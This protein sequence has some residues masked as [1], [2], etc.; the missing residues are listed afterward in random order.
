MRLSRTMLALGVLFA[1]VMALLLWRYDPWLFASALN[2]PIVT[3]LVIA[4]AVV[5]LVVTFAYSVQD[6]KRAVI[7]KEGRFDRLEPGGRM[8]LWPGTEVGTEISLAEQRVLGWPIL[9]YDQKGAETSIILGLTWRIVPTSTKPSFR[10]QRMLLATNDERR[11]IVIQAL[12]STIREIARCTTVE[13]LKGV[14]TNPRCVEAIRQVVAEQLKDD[15]LTLDRLHVVRFIPA[16]K[17]DEP[18]AIRETHTVTETR[19]WADPPRAIEPPRVVESAPATPAAPPARRPDP[20]DQWGAPDSRL[21]YPLDY[22]ARP[23]SDQPTAG[24]D[25]KPEGKAASGSEPSA[26]AATPPNPG[27]AEPPAPGRTGWWHIERTEEHTRGIRIK[28]KDKDKEK[29]KDK[30]KGKDADK[31]LCCP[32]CDR[33]TDA[34]PRG[35]TVR[36]CASCGGPV[37]PCA[38]CGGQKEPCPRCGH[39]PR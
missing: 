20:T 37:A 2:H 6:P 36:F 14:L 23:A 1:G 29:E 16:E 35:L 19:S 25:A 38:T 8:L 30:E 4:G 21:I 22:P 7:F 24:A 15:A 12:E 17:K 31:P 28:D 3:A 27:A 10:E 34:Q 13:N 32:E 33:P 5:W 39:T 11:R 26:K 18:V 9:A